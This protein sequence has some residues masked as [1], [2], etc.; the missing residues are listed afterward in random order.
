MYRALATG[1]IG[2]KLPF[3]E[4]ARLAAA[5]GF[6]GVAVDIGEINELGLESA[7][8]L[9]GKS[10]IIPALTGMPVDFRGDDATFD[11]DMEALPAFAQT[12][13]DLGCTRVATWIKPW[14]E[15]LSYAARFEQ[16]RVR[17]ARI[18][19]VL[20]RYGMRYGLEFVGPE[21]LRK[22]KPHPFIHDTDGLLELIRAVGA[23]NLG[24]LLDSFHWY[25]SG[26]DAE[27]LDKLS[28]QMVVAV[29]VNDAVAD[30][31]RREQLD[32][33]R[34]MPGETG[35]IDMATFMGRLD[36]MGYSGP[37]VVEPFCERIRALPPEEAIA[38]TARS[39]DKIWEFVSI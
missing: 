17:T 38:A 14:H 26:G 10:Q 19:E 13:S 24:F 15:T 25:T 34:A 6:E 36:H 21:T 20:A 33:M 12:M 8:R 22:G 27:D 2:V 30:V 16:M 37:V 28:D 35:A 9:L 4:V 18:C 5:Y 31:P 29:H 3:Q 1:P 11:H 39:L 23:D 7:Q 32:H